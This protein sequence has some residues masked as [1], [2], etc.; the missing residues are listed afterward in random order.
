[1]TDNN[2]VNA[3]NKNALCYIPLAAFFIHFTETKKTNELKKHI[4]YGI[5]LFI[6]YS[7]LSFVISWLFWGL[8]F[9][10]YIWFSWYLWYKAYNWEDV[11][12]SF[13]DEF[14]DWKIDKSDKN[15]KDSSDKDDDVLNF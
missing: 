4:R 3:R 13:I 1:M 8:L 15:K 12:L 10:L 6:A 7:L 9:V 2:T 11:N 14:I 5:I